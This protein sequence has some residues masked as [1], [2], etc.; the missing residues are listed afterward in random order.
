V[1]GRAKIVCEG[2][3]EEKT[4]VSLSENSFVIKNYYFYRDINSVIVV[5]FEI[6]IPLCWLA[7]SIMCHVEVF[8]FSCVLQQEEV[9]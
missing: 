4:I 5:V 7:G 1:G 8:V 6:C 9:E 3:G 2:S